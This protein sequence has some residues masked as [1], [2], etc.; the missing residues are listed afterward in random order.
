MPPA[1]FAA[2]LR[3]QLDAHDFGEVGGQARFCRML[4]ERY[5]IDVLETSV[6]QWLL[7]QRVP[8]RH[9]IHAVLDLLQVHGDERMMALRLADGFAPAQVE[10]SS[11]DKAA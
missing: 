8:A 2:F 9:R 6:S 7:G 5:G 3:Q 11:P 10:Q 1:T 4:K